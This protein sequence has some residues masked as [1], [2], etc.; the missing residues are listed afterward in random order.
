MIL[1]CFLLV[2][3]V[4]VTSEV[5]F[6]VKGRKKS[7]FCS[8]LFL[9][10]VIM[11]RDDEH[12]FNYFLRKPHHSFPL[13]LRKHALRN[14]TL[15]IHKVMNY[16]SFKISLYFMLEIADSSLGVIETGGACIKRSWLLSG[17]LADLV[18]LL[19]FWPWFAQTCLCTCDQLSCIIKLVMWQLTFFFF[20]K[21]WRG[22]FVSIDSLALL[23]RVREGDWMQGKG[24]LKEA[25][26]NR[27]QRDVVMQFNDKISFDS[28][29]RGNLIRKWP[30]WHIFK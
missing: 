26:Q 27:L 14:D 10:W 3:A 7:P 24:T 11:H 17:C 2:H 21:G 22:R 12:I 19:Q 30:T 13:S 9:V 8:Y 23:Q 16:I 29:L 6:A 15:L 4:T 20:L 5:E 28:H 18:D 25:V 1:F